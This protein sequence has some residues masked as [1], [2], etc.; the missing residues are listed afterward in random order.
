MGKKGLKAYH[1]DM[2]RTNT[3]N[4][5]EKLNPRSSGEKMTSA[6]IIAAVDSL[7]C[8][9]WPEHALAMSNPMKLPI[10]FQ[11][12]YPIKWHTTKKTVKYISDH[13]REKWLPGAPF[14]GLADGCWACRMTC[15]CYVYNHRL[16]HD[17]KISCGLAALKPNMML[18]DKCF[19]SKQQFLKRLEIN[20]RYM[21]FTMADQKYLDKVKTQTGSCHHA[22]EQVEQAKEV[23][24]GARTDAVKFSD[25]GKKLGMD[26]AELIM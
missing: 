7:R 24:F 16:R 15:L 20:H 13:I 3:S 19:L 14:V 11:I 1:V 6:T 10:Q 25:A 8:V 5:F 26:I 17:V 12:L 9:Y 21:V 18:R 4:V 22:M 23:M 2:M